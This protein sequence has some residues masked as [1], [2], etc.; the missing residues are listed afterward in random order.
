M[1]VQLVVLQPGAERP[2]HLGGGPGRRDRDAVLGHGADLEALA[3]QP[4]AGTVDLACAR[5]EPRF[6]LCRGQVVPVARATRRADRLHV[7]LRSC[8][9][10]QF[11]HHLEVH[12]GG[13]GYGANRMLAGSRG[14]KGPRQG[15]LARS[16][17]TCR[18]RSDNAADHCRARKAGHPTSAISVLRRVR[19]MS[20]SLMAI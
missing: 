6:P 13:F 1:A 17:C 5:R 16:G 20:A 15:G 12:R 14:N 9:I 4:L 3:D 7:R 19:A 2:L 11:Q 18:L 8:C 10:G